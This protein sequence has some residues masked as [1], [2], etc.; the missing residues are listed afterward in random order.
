MRW[1]PTSTRRRRGQLG[2]LA[3][4]C[5]VK[6]EEVEPPDFTEAA[7]L[8]W[9][10]LMAE[11][12]A[13][14]PQ[15]RAASSSGIEMFGDDAVK[16]ARASTRAYAG[17]LDYADYIRGLARRTTIQ[18]AWQLFFEKYSVMIMPVCFQPPFPIDHDQ[19]G[20][21]AVAYMLDAHHPMLAVSILGFPGLSAPVSCENRTPVGVQI[22]GPRFG[23]DL[24]FEAGEIIEAQYSVRT[25]I[26]PVG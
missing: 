4:S 20:D 15:E 16:R 22:V 12:R 14:S 9:A 11:E 6:E 18:R 25:P 1:P 13:A 2:D 23:E 21:A 26:D 3:G 24:C 7:N 8:F 10:L 19:Q 17:D 5:R